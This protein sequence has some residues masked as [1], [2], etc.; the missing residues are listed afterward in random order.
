MK[1]CTQSPWLCENI[2]NYSKIVDYLGQHPYS[3][4]SIICKFCLYCL[5]TFVHESYLQNNLE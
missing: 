3:Q 5:I 1:P 4:S 2:Q